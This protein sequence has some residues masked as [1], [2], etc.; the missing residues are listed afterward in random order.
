MLGI[1]KIAGYL[2]PDRVS[3][4]DKK[5]KF[6]V[7]DNFIENKLGVITRTVKNKDERASDLC[8]KAYE[9]LSGKIDLKKED[10][11]C[12]V[13]V[14][15][16]PDYNIP[17]TSA[18]VHGK[19]GLSPD[20][21]CFDISLGCSGFVYGLSVIISFMNENNLKNGLL[22]TSDPYSDIIDPEDKNTSLL[23]GDA[24]SVTYINENGEW[25]PV[26]F[27]FGTSGKDYKML[28]CEDRLFMNGRAIFN[29]AVVNIPVKIKE[30]M[31]RHGVIDSDVDKYIFHQASKYIVDILAKRLNIDGSK[32]PF[33]M[34]DY[35]NTI[36]SSIPLIL[37]E[38]IENRENS[39]L[40]ISGF[41]VGLSW[42]N[43]ILK[44]I[45]D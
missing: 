7:D 29:F 22:F 35:G 45:K 9:N 28:I 34:Q 20:C 1:K 33:G 6:G 38:E 25:A 11:D 5:D 21:A 2:P 18:V 13:V 19:L 17:H 42:G 26:G 15:Q 30:L 10:I 24:A 41:G 16:N 37:E 14:T 40:V 31:E 27:N 43:A 8:L 39:L 4:Y 44:Y 23:F 36:S 32:V 3:N 12:C